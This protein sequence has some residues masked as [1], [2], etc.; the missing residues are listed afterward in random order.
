MGIEESSQVNP[1]QFR[2]AL[3][4]SI[5]LCIVAYLVYAKLTHDEDL[6]RL[7]AQFSYRWWNVKTWWKRKNEPAWKRELRAYFTVTPN[8]VPEI[9]TES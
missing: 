1:K 4:A 9:K 5:G 3:D 7:R 2:E 8:P 6:V